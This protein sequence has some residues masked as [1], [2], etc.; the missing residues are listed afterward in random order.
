M[1][2]Q[3]DELVSNCATCLTNSNANPHEALQPHEIPNRPRQRIATDLFEWKGRT[4]L[5]IVDH[6]SRY[7]EVAEFQNSKARTIIAKTKS[8]FSRR[9]IPEIVISDNG[10]QYLSDE[11]RQFAEAYDF[12][13]TTISPGYPQPGGL[14]EKTVQT[15]K[16][17][18]EKCQ[19]TKQRSTSSL[20]RL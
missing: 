18:L 16:Q 6:Y 15:V 5:I 14:H 1:N 10:P 8:I 17:L 7:P 2:S 20:T 12:R 9:G 4:H 13:H 11:Y 3:I 19:A